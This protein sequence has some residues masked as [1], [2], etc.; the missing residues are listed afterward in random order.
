MGHKNNTTNR[1]TMQSDIDTQ[2]YLSPCTHRPED[3]HISGRNMS[4]ITML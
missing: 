4:V 2:S 1:I 3:G